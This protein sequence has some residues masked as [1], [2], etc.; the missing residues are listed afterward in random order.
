M[1]EREALT[2]RLLAQLEPAQVMELAAWVESRGT[3]P[4]L[5]WKTEKEGLLWTLEAGAYTARVE[6][7]LVAGKIVCSWEVLKGRWLRASA[8]DGGHRLAERAL[9]GFLLEDLASLEEAVRRQSSLTSGLR[10]VR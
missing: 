8:P 2:L 4:I 6:R 7:T 1:T 9:F 3:E 5:A 10:V